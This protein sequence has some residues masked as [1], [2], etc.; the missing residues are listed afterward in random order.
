MRVSHPGWCG[1]STV[2]HSA[3]LRLPMTILAFVHRLRTES[4][5][6]LELF[7]LPGLA[8]LLPWSWCL[9]VFS[10]LARKPWLYRQEVER[11]V[12]HATALGVLTGDPSQWAAIRRLTTLIDHAD[13][14][15]V[16]YRGLEW[17]RKVFEVHGS[18]P[19]PG[20][21]GLVCTFHWGCGAWAL[22][23]MRAA[24]LH[25]HA[26]VAALD[27]DCFR[28]RSVLHAYAKAR[29][30]MVAQELGRSTLDVSASLRPVLETLNKGEQLLAVLDVPA[31]QVSASQCVTLL[32]LQAR[33]PTA[34]LRL[35]VKQ[36]V[37]ITLFLAG[38]HLDGRRFLEVRTLGPHTDVEVLLNALYAELDRVLRENPAAWHF[39]GEAERFFTKTGA[40]NALRTN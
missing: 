20:T 24:G 29:T 23:H 11:A 1:L 6:L 5:D 36:R 26:L 35:A 9:R 16:R 28:G 2:G 22:P 7:L 32:G 25:V 27:A 21:A 31:D 19:A 17:M 18:W 30:A 38:Q 4:R 10:W 33:V 37:P 39:W 34:M 15:L 13:Y 3:A 12:H 8:I 40:D 14:F